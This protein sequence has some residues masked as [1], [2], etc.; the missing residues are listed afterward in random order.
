MDLDPSTRR[1]GWACLVVTAAVLVGVAHGLVVADD[2]SID[3]GAQAADEPARVPVQ[4]V[5]HDR[6][7]VTAKASRHSVGADTIP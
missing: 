1:I 6:P 7:V 2:S 4:V 3:A 5:E